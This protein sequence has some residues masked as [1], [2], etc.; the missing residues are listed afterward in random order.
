MRSVPFS[1]GLHVGDN[2]DFYEFGNWNRSKIAPLQ[3]ACPEDVRPLR[4]KAP[5]KPL[6]CF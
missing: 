4:P 3:G 5:A 1:A 2:T 6:T